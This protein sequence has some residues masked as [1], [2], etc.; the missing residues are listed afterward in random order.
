MV[1][2]LEIDKLAICTCTD[3]ALQLMSRGLFPCAPSFPSLAVDL[4]MLDFV[5]ELFVNAAPNLTAWCNTL[6]SFLNSRKFKLTTRVCILLIC[7][8]NTNLFIQQN[9]LRGRFGNTL[10]WYATLVNSKK[11]CMRN[12]LDNIRKSVVLDT[13]QENAM[14]LGIY[15]SSLLVFAMLIIAR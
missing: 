8:D 6:E 7:S 15:L 10:H 5:Q 3:P 14:V 9:S 1:S 11:L 13:Y 12:Y 2:C 4:Q